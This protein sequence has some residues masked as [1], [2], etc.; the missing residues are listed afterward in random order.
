[1]SIAERLRQGPVEY[2]KVFTRYVLPQ[3]ESRIE[4]RLLE[5]FTRGI[6]NMAERNEVIMSYHTRCHNLANLP[7]DL[8]LSIEK[9]EPSVVKKNL[10]DYI[11]I[12]IDHEGEGISYHTVSEI[13]RYTIFP[14]NHWRRMFR[15]RGFGL[16]EQQ[17]T[18]Y[19]GTYGLMTR[20]EG[21]RLTNDL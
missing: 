8:D 20:E 21:L 1:M 14:E 11:N 2:F 6:T 4:E 3:I 9:K 12:F 10:K 16:I 5:Q 7:E 13:G 19:T 15:R 17:D 18:A